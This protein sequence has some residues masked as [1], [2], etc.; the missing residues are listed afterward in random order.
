MNYLLLEIELKQNENKPEIVNKLIQKT[1]QNIIL[2]I[3]QKEDM[4]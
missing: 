4:K 3:F 1:E 2:L